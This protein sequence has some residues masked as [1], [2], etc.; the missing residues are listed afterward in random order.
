MLDIRKEFYNKNEK[1]TLSGMVGKTIGGVLMQR[2]IP[3]DNLLNSKNIVPAIIIAIVVI[4]AL[5]FKPFTVIP[6]GQRGIVFNQF[7]GVDKNRIL[8][9]GFH[10]IV[11]FVESVYKMEVR[12]QKQDFEAT[13]ASQDLQE[14]RAR[15]AVN[16]HLDPLKVADIYQQV[17]PDYENKLI[18]PS[19]QE[20]IKAVTAQYNAT[21][22]IS[23]RPE[24]KDKVV[25]Y[26]KK[27]LSPF[28]ILI[29]DVS[30]T[31]FSFT[32]EFVKAI[33]AKQ[34]AE[35]E[36][37]KKQY[38][39]KT[40]EQE[41]AIEVARAEGAKKATIAKAEGQ[42][43]AQKLLRISVSPEIIKL[44]QIE[45]QM[46]AIKKWDGKM[47]TVSGGSLPMINLGNV[48]GN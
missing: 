5:I 6:A 32:P 47:P 37:F 21:H 16:Y 45:A 17:G 30:I 15:I 2:N 31:D 34:V 38:E 3:L 22:L 24:V 46:D 35:Q 10:M 26:M 7:K 9:E 27:R 39:L 28:N 29:D 8:N 19:V 14:V 20:S 1:Q 42:A 41:A 44:K 43:E 23:K 25:D 48:M 18:S 40:A 4:L 13:A 11:P 36:S 33:E 12:V